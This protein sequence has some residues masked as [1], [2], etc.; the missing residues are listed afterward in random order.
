MIHI[1]EK[2]RA[3][4]RPTDGS[5][6][7]QTDRQRDRSSAVQEKPLYKSLKCF[8]ARVRLRGDKEAKESQLQHS[9][10]TFLLVFRKVRK[11]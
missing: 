5:R 7:I 3:R 1:E 6:N 10:K 11:C 2:E 8:A 4:N 9:S